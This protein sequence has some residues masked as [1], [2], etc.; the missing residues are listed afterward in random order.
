MKYAEHWERYWNEYFNIRKNPENNIKFQCALKLLP[1]KF[2]TLLDVGGGNGFFIDLLRDRSYS[3]DFT[4]IDGSPTAIK[5]CKEKNIRSIL[6]DFDGKPLPFKDD[7]FDVITCLDVLEHLH[8]PWFLLDEM[9]R[10][11]RKYIIISCPNFASIVNR[12]DVLLGNPPRFMA[13][14]YGNQKHGGHIQFITFNTL[15]YQIRRLGMEIVEY[16]AQ[17]TI[18]GKKIPAITKIRRL[19]PNIFGTIC[20]KAEK[21]SE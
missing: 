15:K 16:S 1:E 21:L 19:F 3:A 14:R 11:S 20:I 18:F 4:V 9:K 2:E 8:H 10:V 12:M 17:D 6:Y 13:D 5:K 7:S